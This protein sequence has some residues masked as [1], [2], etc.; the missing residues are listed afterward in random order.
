MVNYQLKGLILL[1]CCLLTTSCS[2][3]STERAQQILF[4]PVE[5]LHSDNR[6][7]AKREYDNFRLA[8]D[9][10]LAQPSV[11]TLGDLQ[12]EWV[13]FHD[14]LHRFQ[15]LANPSTQESFSILIDSWPIEPGFIDNLPMY[16]NSGIVSD[17]SIPIDETSLRQQHQF[18][19]L[20]EAAI[21]LHAIEYLIFSRSLNDFVPSEDF[22]VKR[23][24]VLLST[25]VSSLEKDL[26]YYLNVPH[27]NK[28]SP[29]TLETLMKILEIGVSHLH[30]ESLKLLVNP[31][32]TFSNKS[33]Q[34]LQNQIDLVEQI[35]FQPVNL[36]SALVYIDEFLTRD[37]I[38]TVREL[39]A[40]LSSD[41]KDEEIALRCSSLLEGL[42]HQ[43]RS[44]ITL[45]NVDN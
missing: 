32:S 31:H 7:D 23:R 1:F 29:P 5:K 42:K 28:N 6:I 38:H 18:T 33:R 37:V 14:T 2:Q 39:R 44:L 15:F 9:S 20:S 41:A 3:K 34:N 10:F 4:D 40:L 43:L 16:P 21:G 19:D 26:N 12:K 11:T 36:G 45:L 17:V 22:R 35:L 30:H 25:M 24:R 8:M 27:F 13:Y